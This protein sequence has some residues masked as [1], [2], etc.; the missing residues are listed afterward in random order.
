[1]SVAIWIGLIV[2]IIMVLV[3]IPTGVLVWREL[4]NLLVT[5]EF[6]YVAKYRLTQWAKKNAEDHFDLVLDLGLDLKAEQLTG[7][8][9]YTGKNT[10]K[11]ERRAY[12]K[13]YD[14]RISELT[15]GGI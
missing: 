2:S 13:A 11:W 10:P 8:E 7:V 6:R 15:S 1:M 5:G 9:R 14:T 3:A 4:Y 12:I